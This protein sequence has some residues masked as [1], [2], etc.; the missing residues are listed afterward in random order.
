MIYIVGWLLVYYYLVFSLFVRNYSRIFAILVLSVL[1]IIAILRGSVGTDTSV[2]E[3]LASQ[4]EVWQGIEPGFWFLMYLFSLVFNE[5]VIVVRIFSLLFVVILIW[6]LYRSDNEELFILMT[7]IVPLFFYNLS[8]NVI[9]VGLALSLLLIAFQ[10]ERRERYKNSL[11]IAFSALMFHYSMLFVLFYLW[12]THESVNF[13]FLKFRNFIILSS[14]IFFSIV[15]ILVNESYFFLKFY[16]Y[17]IREAPSLF[18]GL[19]RLALGFVLL[20]SLFFSKIEK[21]YKYRIIAVSVFFMILFFSLNIYITPRFLDLINFLIPIS[22][23]RAYRRLQLPVETPF[24]VALF[25]AGLA[26]AVGMYRY[27]L[28]ESFWTSSPFLPYHTVFDR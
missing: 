28:Y 20:S 14:T 26:G 11:I 3:R 18:S 9:R 24:K 12:F 10:E 4:A 13:K 1:G 21:S 25:V 8:M 23:L 22:I 7:F 17:V 5:P 15:L 27:M 16:H 19:S 2:Y 6:Y